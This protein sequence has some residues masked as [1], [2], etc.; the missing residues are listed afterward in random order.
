MEDVSSCFF[1]TTWVFCRGDPALAVRQ[2]LQSLHFSFP[3]ITELARL[4]IP[5]KMDQPLHFSCNLKDKEEETFI[6]LSSG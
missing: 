4:Q 6:Y 3:C 1:F 2:G 5:K